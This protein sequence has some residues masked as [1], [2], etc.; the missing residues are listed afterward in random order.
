[1]MEFATCHLRWIFV[2]LLQWS[3]QNF[4]LAVD[5]WCCDEHV[6]SVLTG[7]G[8]VEKIVFAKA[9]QNKFDNNWNSIIE[10][11]C[12]NVI[13]RVIMLYYVWK[14]A[15]KTASGPFISL[16]RIPQPGL[17]CVCKVATQSGSQFSERS[18][19]VFAFTCMTNW[20]CT[21]CQG[22]AIPP[23]HIGLFLGIFIF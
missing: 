2:L 20:W 11:T 8:T 6:S 12:N 17:K 10:L 9:A 4:L 7:K 5:C 15:L 19:W 14:I 23:G 18:K 3:T 22:I 21:P 16:L 13:L 1:M